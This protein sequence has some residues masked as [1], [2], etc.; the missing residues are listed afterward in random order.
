MDKNFLQFQANAFKN[1][2]EL[3]NYK[4]TSEGKE[5]NLI[6]FVKSQILTKKYI[7]IYS[8]IIAEKNDS[9]WLKFSITNDYVEIFKNADNFDV[10]CSKFVEL[11]NTYLIY[12]EKIDKKLIDNLS[13]YSSL[14]FYVDSQSQTNNSIDTEKIG[15]VY[16]PSLKNLIYTPSDVKF[17]EH[18]YSTY[19]N[20]CRNF[21]SYLTFNETFADK[22]KSSINIIEANKSIIL[23]QAGV[24]GL[25]PLESNFLFKPEDTN[26]Q[27][28]LDLI[29][30]NNSDEYKFDITDSNKITDNNTIFNNLLNVKDVAK[31]NFNSKFGS[32]YID[33]INKETLL[34]TDYKFYALSSVK[35][36]NDKFFNSSVNLI[37]NKERTVSAVLNA[38]D[39]YY[40]V[41]LF[42][43]FD[44]DVTFD[45]YYDSE[46]ERVILL[47]NRNSF[48]KVPVGFNQ[49]TMQIEY[50]TKEV[51]FIMT[52]PT[53]K[54]YGN[55][56]KDVWLYSYSLSTSLK[57]IIEFSKESEDIQK[58]RIP[59]EFLNQKDIIQ[60]EQLFKIETIEEK[61]NNSKLTGKD[62]LDKVVQYS[63]EYVLTYAQ[64]VFKTVQADDGTMKTVFESYEPITTDKRFFIQGTQE[65]TDYVWKVNEI[66]W[67]YNKNISIREMIAYFVAK[68]DDYHYRL[69]SYRILGLDCYLLKEKL[70]EQL[71]KELLVCVE[72]FAINIRNKSIE[73]PLKITYKYEY[74]TGN[75]YTKRR[76]L[77]PTNV[78]NLEVYPMRESIMLY[79]GD[80]LGENIIQNQISFLE[81]ELI[82]PKEM[83]WNSKS[84]QT[85][86][87]SHPLDPIFSR[88]GNQIKKKNAYYS[89]LL[90]TLF[91]DY[92]NSTNLTSSDLVKDDVKYAYTLRL[93][94]SVSIPLRFIKE[95]NCFKVSILPKE[96]SKNKNGIDVFAVFGQNDTKNENPL[97]TG[98][99]AINSQSCKD[100]ID[101]K[102]YKGSLQ[103]E[104]KGTGA[105]YSF[106]KK[107]DRLTTQSYRNLYDGSFISEDEKNSEDIEPQNKKIIVNEILIAYNTKQP[108]AIIEGDIQ[109]NK[110]MQNYVDEIDALKFQQ[111]WNETYNYIM[112]PKKFD[113][114]EGYNDVMKLDNS[115]FPIFIEHSRFFKDKLSNEFRLNDNQIDGIKF[116]VGNNNSSL[117]AHEVGFGKTT[118]SICSLSHNFL[119]G[120][121]KRTLISVPN[122]TYVN[123]ITE[124]KGQTLSNGKSLKGLLPQINLVELANARKDV[125]LRY[126]AKTFTQT[127]GIKK[128]TRSQ[129]QNINNFKETT[130][131]IISQ[132]KK[133]GQI[134]FQDYDDKKENVE[135][136]LKFI[137]KTFDE[138]LSDWRLEDFFNEYFTKI[139]TESGN[140]VSDLESKLSEIENEEDE[141][142]ENINNSTKYSS[143]EKLDKEKKARDKYEKKKN[144]LFESSVRD[145][146]N[147]V[148][149]IINSESNSIYDSMGVYDDCFLKNY[150]VI[151]STHQAIGQLRI[152]DDTAIS[153][154]TD[155]KDE[156]P[157]TNRKTGKLIPSVF[158]RTL[159]KNPIGFDKLNIDS[160][161]VDE[162]HN[163]NE[164][165]AY[166]KK[167][168]SALIPEKRRKAYY[169]SNDYPFEAL[170]DTG[171]PYYTKKGRGS[172]LS[173]II[174]FNVQGKKTSNIKATLFGIA[175][176]LQKNKENINIMLLSAT[177]FV[178]NLY[179]MIGVFNLLKKF[180]QPIT[181][182]SNFLY[183]EWDWENDQRG[184]TVL[185]VQT[186]NF[187]NHE[188]RNNWIKMFSQFYTFDKR[189]SEQRPNKFTYPFDC[190]NQSNQYE[191][192]CNTNVYLDFSTEQFNIYKN[193]GKYVD[194]TL[195]YGNIVPSVKSSTKVTKEVYVNDDEIKIVKEYIDPTNDYYDLEE[196]SKIFINGNWMDAIK[197]TKNPYQK[198]IA[199]IY[200]VIKD[201]IERLSSDEDEES[202]KSLGEGEEQVADINDADQLT[203]IGT[204]TQGTRALRGQDIGK[205][206]ALSPYMVTPDDAEAGN[207]NPNLPPLYGMNTPE[208]LTKSAVNFVETSPKIYFVAKSIECLIK[209][210]RD[211]NE[212]IT[213]QIIYMTIGQNFWYG[214]VKYNGMELIKAYLKNLLGF[215][216]KFV[217]EEIDELTSSS[218]ATKCGIVSNVITE[219]KT[220]TKLKKYD[221]DE[222]QILSGQSQDAL[223]KNA[224]AKAFNDGRIKILIGSATIKE[225]INLQGGGTHGN[226]T[227]YI[228]TADYAPMDFM[229]LEGRIWRQ[230]NP[231]EN[232]RIVYTLIKNSIDSHIYS[233]LNEKIKK[234]KTMLE[235]GVYDFKE[236]QFDKDIEGVSLALN[237]N[238]DEKIKILWSKETKKIEGKAKELDSI[239][240]RLDGVKNIYSEANSSLNDLLISYN[241]IAKGL[242]DYYVGGYIRAEYSA[243][244]SKIT[245]EYTA[246]R[247]ELAEVL[248]NKFKADILEWEK[249]RDENEKINKENKAK[250]LPKVE[251]NI[252]KPV[253]KDNPLYTPDYSN[254]ELEEE[255]AL[256]EA[257]ERIIDANEQKVADK[258]FTEDEITY[259]VPLTSSS[260]YSEISSNVNKLLNDL[261]VVNISVMD[262]DEWRVINSRISVT[263][264][265]FVLESKSL[266]VD[267]GFTKAIKDNS[268]LNTRMSNILKKYKIDFSN[269]TLF[270]SF[271]KLFINGGK[272]EIIFSDYQTFVVGVGETIATIDMVIND[273][274]SKINAN[275]AK[276]SEKN[277]FYYKYRTIFMDEEE[278]I[279]KERE[280][281]TNMKQY[282]LVD[283]NKFCETNKFI[284][285][286]GKYTQEQTKEMFKIKK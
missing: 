208:N 51:Y 179:Q 114:V 233:K 16:N 230:G 190:K 92:M 171:S 93:P 28:E 234:V 167:Q 38:Y 254:L 46:N 166:S 112:Y 89:S 2:I 127:G 205:K 244:K 155:L 255:K 178:D 272:F 267:Y 21:I 283:V 119:T 111:I 168:I 117:L 87:Y 105:Y 223:K 81:N 134:Y 163:F 102:P 27:I 133:V 101:S 22:G 240:T 176:K 212:D 78:D 217:A 177:P 31:S 120:K 220:Q 126:D 17:E 196:A 90:V 30:F 82:K 65:N 55:L 61:L 66:F 1:L 275:N 68:G 249:L 56:V 200:E 250:K 210:Q 100:W 147:Q 8:E 19:R 185:K 158:G 183:Q 113:N 72:D 128:Y 15:L 214:G 194:G 10:V 47:G 26:K 41:M 104:R 269:V 154:A 199:E 227:I 245:S 219:V 129:I 243:E 103:L 125:F 239:K 77:R 18:D 235:A 278:K 248:N 257:K 174:K 228:L 164:L 25:I 34:Q 95:F 197:D 265:Y 116:H 262:D 251:F 83:T 39:F 161:I 12:D 236:T 237:S 96:N 204:D 276:L 203:G 209:K 280:S 49:T 225:G 242:Q 45:I 274:S 44:T 271:A 42:Q 264:R 121:A 142:I 165:F 160:I 286:R 86:L 84:E 149:A 37:F 277:E 99:D 108:K 35:D 64:K 182:F 69:L 3:F 273:I 52:L 88:G 241:A 132:I 175:N 148:I 181:F 201:E 189:I 135:K 73:T 80:D 106:N 123:W 146:T 238:I 151:I 145:F 76:K 153:V 139:R 144:K 137:E 79:Y 207:I 85:K 74:A 6:D 43:S 211:N 98:D 54:E 58:I 107:L 143:K 136:F 32:Y 268:G 270:K 252:D 156:Y 9:Q 266:M 141:S 138:K 150:T 11:Y 218:T 206:L 91:N 20:L 13:V 14:D 157:I 184:N 258:K 152:D 33:K 36:K 215:D 285:L 232:V 246:K 260:S 224:I 23:N 118:T 110:F 40:A 247:S 94:E 195:A 62:F 263:G 70:I 279:K 29:K 7:P 231:L 281:L 180:Q 53:Q 221:L 259:Y 130:S 59:S 192:N 202:G 4:F 170:S 191:D 229:Q 75:Y 63:E 115:K 187:K 198:E 109:F 122:P 256:K 222:V 169:L 48:V 173:S 282:V 24:Q 284:Y 71:I 216:N 159:T 67:R 261:T 5:F 60:K 50:S 186:S 213:G 162:V 131:Y 188:A 193:L 253:K 140:A 226:S 97:F 124:I 57:E 172:N